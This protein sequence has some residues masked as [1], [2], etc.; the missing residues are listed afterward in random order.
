MYV[1]VGQALHVLLSFQL[2]FCDVSNDVHILLFTSLYV[3]TSDV[4]YVSW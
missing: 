3:Y 4:Q 1:V 2:I